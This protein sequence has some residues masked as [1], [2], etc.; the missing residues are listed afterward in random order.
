MNKNQKRGGLF[1]P[2]A[3]SRFL[4]SESHFKLS[5]EQKQY[6]H[7]HRSAETFVPYTVCCTAV[8][9][10]S[11][12]PAAQPRYWPIDCGLLSA[13]LVNSERLNRSTPGLI[14]KFPLN[15]TSCKT[16]WVGQLQIFQMMGDVCQILL[17]SWAR[18]HYG[19]Q[20]PFHDRFPSAQQQTGSRSSAQVEINDFT[21]P[22]LTTVAQSRIPA[23]R[24]GILSMI[25]SSNKLE[26]VTFSLFVG[27]SA[28]VG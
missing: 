2:T 21:F 10:K 20:H 18:S 22:H 8:A 7:T 24:H 17:V 1:G 15:K 16:P 3:F 26:K 14:I 11:D 9:S 5:H 13:Q 23:W 27:H 28:S 19:N 6:F 25:H 4:R 12:F